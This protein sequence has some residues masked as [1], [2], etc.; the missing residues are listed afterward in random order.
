MSEQTPKIGICTHGC[1]SIH[2]VIKE[3]GHLRRAEPLAQEDTRCCTQLWSSG[4][5]ET[6][7][8]TSSDIWLSLAGAD[9]ICTHTV[10]PSSTW[11]DCGVF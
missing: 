3:Q 11:K 5:Y 4:V 7:F 6:P 2:Q 9:T 1:T 10:F 8:T